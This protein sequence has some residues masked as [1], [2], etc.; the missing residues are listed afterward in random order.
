MLAQR[1]PLAMCLTKI[2]ADFHLN[3]IQII[4]FWLGL[5]NVT[6]W[7]CFLLQGV[8]GKVCRPTGTVTAPPGAQA[9]GLATSDRHPPTCVASAPLTPLTSGHSW[10]DPHLPTRGPSRTGARGSPRLRWGVGL[11]TEGNPTDTCASSLDDL[12]SLI[13]FKQIVSQ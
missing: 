6:Q 10:E 11:N 12:C 13:D 3:I 2:L 8:A 7:F 5:L 4:N 1:Y 9:R